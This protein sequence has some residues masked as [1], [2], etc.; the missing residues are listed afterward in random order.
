MS[1]YIKIEKDL[2]PYKFDVKLVG[3]TYTFEIKYN[4]RHDFF[5]VAISKPDGVV[6][7]GRKTDI[8]QNRYYQSG[9]ILIFPLVVPSDTTGDAERITWNNLGSSVFLHIGVRE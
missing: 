5:T 9:Y 1:N 7:I 8:K 2:I 4:S 3:T 6:H